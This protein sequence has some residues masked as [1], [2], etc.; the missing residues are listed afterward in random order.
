MGRG[1]HIDID[2]FDQIITANPKDAIAFYLRGSAHQKLGN[3]ERA[4]SDIEASYRLGFQINEV[5]AN[6]GY[7]AFLLGDVEGSRRD[8]TSVVTNEP[9]NAL[10]NA[11]YGDFLGSRHEYALALNYLNNANTLDPDLGM[12]YVQTAKILLTL[13][14]EELAKEAL[15]QSSGLDLPTVPDMIDRGQIYA[16]FRQY[17]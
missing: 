5:I 6:R 13:G 7:T 2:H 12:S 8:L 14:L 17:D 15:N 3:I 11:Y 10:F 4:N 16:F 1:L 9:S